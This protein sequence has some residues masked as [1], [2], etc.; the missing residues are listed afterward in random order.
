[1]QGVDGRQG[2]G[3]IS[4]L[5]ESKPAAP[6]R[7]SVDDHLGTSNLTEGSEQLF[8]VGIADRERKIADIQL[9][10]HLQTPQDLGHAGLTH[11]RLSGLFEMWLDSP[12]GTPG[13]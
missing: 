2:V 12:V 5:D 8:K 3:V 9:L 10:A 1:M 11:V 4:H 6:A 13:G 7:L